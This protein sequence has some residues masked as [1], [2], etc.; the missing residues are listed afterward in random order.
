MG[1]RQIVDRDIAGINK[2]AAMR[3]RAVEGPIVAV[4]REAYARGEV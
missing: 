3:V 1:D 4:Y 2:E